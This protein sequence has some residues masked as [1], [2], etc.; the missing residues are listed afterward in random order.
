[1]L[2]R[3]KFTSIEEVLNYLIAKETPSGM[4]RACKCL[5]KLLMVRPISSVACERSFSCLIKIKTWLRSTM[6]QRG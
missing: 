6:R 3:N 2:K 4:F 1:M 5:L